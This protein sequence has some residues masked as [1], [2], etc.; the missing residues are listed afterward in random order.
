M[1]KERG[2]GNGE[3]GGRGLK[4]RARARRQEVEGVNSPFYSE[5]GIP[6]H[7]QVTVGRGLDKN[8]NRNSDHDS[9]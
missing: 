2:E 8:A 6:G 3:R 7:C 4:D 9:T 5:S 1:W